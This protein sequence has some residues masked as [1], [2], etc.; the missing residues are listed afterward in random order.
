MTMFEKF[1]FLSFM[2]LCLVD[3][4]DGI[5]PTTPLSTSHVDLN[6]T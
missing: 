1:K 4:G 6:T 5:A 3:N 2:V